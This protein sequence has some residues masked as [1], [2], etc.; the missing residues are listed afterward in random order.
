MGN[1]DG[2]TLVSFERWDRDVR[3]EAQV[4][5]GLTPD[6][7]VS[8]RDLTRQDYTMFGLYRGDA[9][10]TRHSVP[11]LTADTLWELLVMLHDCPGLRNDAGVVI[12][13]VQACDGKVVCLSYFAPKSGHLLHFMDDYSLSFMQAW[14]IYQSHS[15]YLDGTYQFKRYDEAV[16]CADAYRDAI[17]DGRL[18]A[19][20]GNVV[21][22]LYCEFYLKAACPA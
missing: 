14:D 4:I 21:P 16:Q 6:M 18:F 5:A 9:P 11:L 20:E 19:D 15:R 7:E 12:G 2:K 8:L 22:G 1:V 13:G 17:S 3:R 10:L